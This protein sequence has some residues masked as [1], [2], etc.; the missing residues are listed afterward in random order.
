VKPDLHR[1][2]L[3]Q[4]EFV[5][6]IFLFIV[7]RLLGN[8]NKNRGRTYSCCTLYEPED[9]NRFR[10]RSSELFAVVVE[11]ATATKN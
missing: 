8:N 3:L 7:D 10:E 11:A 4:R 9:T 2:R 6:K 1:M 5:C